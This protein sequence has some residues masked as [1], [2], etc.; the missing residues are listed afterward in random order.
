MSFQKYC[1]QRRYVDY[2]LNEI[3]ERKTSCILIY[4]P[5]VEKEEWVEEIKDALESNIF[6]TSYLVE[7]MGGGNLA[8]ILQRV[9]D[10]NRRIE[11]FIDEIKRS[12]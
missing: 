9:V 1:A 11:E 2:L 8:G 3:K 4:F 6:I 10:R 5:F 7:G 12:S